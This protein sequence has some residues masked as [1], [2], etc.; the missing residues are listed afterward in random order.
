[1]RFIQK[2]FL[3][4][5]FFSVA[6]PSLAADT[7]GNESEQ[8]EEIKFVENLANTF[9][10]DIFESNKSEQEK[11]NTFK[12]VF[13]SNCDINFI[14]KFVLGK[15]WKNASDEEKKSFTESFSNAVVLTWAGRFKEYNGQKI[16]VFGVRSANSGQSYVDSSVINPEHSADKPIA[17]IWR[18]SNKDGKMQIVDLII[19]GV[20]MA[21][22]YRNEYAAVLQAKGGKMESLIETLEDKNKILASSLGVVVQ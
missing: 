14:S 13:L 3:A 22:T 17:L 21:M 8:A 7:D 10:N 20:S 9:I 5:I 15:A 6:S 4:L 12:K 2:I 18:I 11:V 19:E 1:M 16:K